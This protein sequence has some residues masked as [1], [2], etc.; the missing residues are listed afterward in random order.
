[1][2]LLWVKDSSSLL[3]HLEV[4]FGLDAWRREWTAEWART[5]DISPEVPSCGAAARRET[6]FWR[7]TD[8]GRVLVGLLIGIVL[9]PAA[10]LM[11]LKYGRPP[12]AAADAPF[13]FEKFVTAVPLKA[14][15]EYEL[16]TKPPVKSDEDTLVTGAHIY[17]QECAVCHGYHGQASRF[18][19]KMYPTAPPLWEK[20]GNSDVVGVSDDPLGETYWK[21][22]NGIRLSGMPGFKGILTPAQMW[23]VSML[24]ANAN[25]PLPP[26]ALAILRGDGPAGGSAAQSGAA[27]AAA[28]NLPSGSKVE[29]SG[30]PN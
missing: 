3:N 6:A 5:A 30:S 15:I 10:A 12:V 17:A 4:N 27:A 24:L 19:M 8:M 11:Y 26:A 7:R 18:G 20:H 16:V 14:R 13:P 21:V 2:I 29:V 28:L 22:E 1:V 25:K 23:Q 9:V